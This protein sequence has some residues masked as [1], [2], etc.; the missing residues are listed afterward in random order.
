MNDVVLFKDLFQEFKGRLLLCA[1]ASILTGLSNGLLLV[2]TSEVI[3][4]T[5]HPVI[6]AIAGFSG[7]LLFWATFRHITSVGITWI[8]ETLMVRIR[9]LI[10]GDLQDCELETFEGI[11]RAEVH[12]ALTEDCTTISRF[13][14]D[15]VDLVSAAITLLV[16]LIYLVWLSPF[17]FFLI[18]AMIGIGLPWY[19]L[20]QQSAGRGLSASRSQIDVIYGFIL[21][22]LNGFKE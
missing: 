17:A 2:I 3:A 9:A 14:P 18:L 13:V 10:L 16:C 22:F 6:Y 4:G 20:R 7:M 19:L 11:G 15:L 8:V 21:D 5:D 1:L 12:N